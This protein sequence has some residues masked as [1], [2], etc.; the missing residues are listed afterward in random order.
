MP[1]KRHLTAH[2][3]ALMIL[4]LH[5][6]HG[7]DSGRDLSRFRISRRTLTLI[8][9][10]AQLRQSHIDET[11]YALRDFGWVMFEHGEHLCLLRMDRIDNWQRVASKRIRRE[12]HQATNPDEAF[13]FEALERSLNVPDDTAEDD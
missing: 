12:V 1:I 10:R 4:R 8:S 13:D 9:G 11:G 7:E 3:T 6:T 2:Q 5:Q